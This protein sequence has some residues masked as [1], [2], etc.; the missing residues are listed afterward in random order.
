MKIIEATTEATH[1]PS[2]RYRC[3]HL[4][5][6]GHRCG[7]PSLRG[8]HFCYYHHTTR[9][10][11]DERRSRRDWA[12]FELPQLEDRSSVL[13]AVNEVLQRIAC[14]KLPSKQA[15]LLLY[16]LQIASQNL[17]DT[18]EAVSEEDR[19]EEVIGNPRYGDLAPV[20]EFVEDV[21]PAIAPGEP[22]NSD[23]QPAS[24]EPHATSQTLAQPNTPQPPRL[25]VSYGIHTPGYYKQSTLEP[26]KSTILPNLQ[27]NADTERPQRLQQ[28]YTREDRSG[29]RKRSDTRKNI[30]IL[31]AAEDLLLPSRTS[32][33]P[34][35]SRALL[36]TRHPILSGAKSKNAASTLPWNAAYR[37]RENLPASS[38]PLHRNFT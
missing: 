8:E 25:F 5:V 27:A 4:F 13:A 32:S 38:L 33:R 22:S 30:V 23:G 15:G 11:A 26:V 18:G 24:A 28:S 35:N 9:G 6:D 37:P 3:R 12:E 19:P 1:E 2:K 7:S 20:A 31:R 34:R 21:K 17:P 10:F 16:G 29:T 36:R 14:D